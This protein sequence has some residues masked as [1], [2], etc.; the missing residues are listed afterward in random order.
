MKKQY[1]IDGMFFGS[2]AILVLTD[3]LWWFIQTFVLS[4]FGQ[5]RLMSIYM[6]IESLML[7]IFTG[8][9]GAWLDKHS[10]FYGIKV[11]LCIVTILS[12]ISCIAINFA[13]KLNYLNEEK[14][15]K[16]S[17]SCY[18]SLL[19]SVISTSIGSFFYN[20]IRLVLTKDWIVI[21]S[22]EF[23][24]NEFDDESIRSK[25]FKNDKKLTYYNTI[26][27][28]IYQIS[29]IIEPIITGFVMN[30]L[31]Y[32]MASI[33]FCIFNISMW[34]IISLF[35]NFIYKNV[36]R[37]KRIKKRRHEEEK[38]KTICNS[39]I[40]T[41]IN[42][43]KLDVKNELKIIKFL[44][45]PVSFVAVA[46]SLT[47]MNILQLSG[48]SIT[49]ASINNV[50]EQ[51]L[52]LFRCIGS[53]FALIGTILYPLFKKFFGLKKT[54]FIGFFM[55][56]IFLLPSVISI[57]LPGSIFEYNIFFKELTNINYSIYI[58]LIGITFSRLG[59]FI[60]DCAVNQQMQH[61]I[62]EEIRSEIFGIHTSL[63]Y[64]LTLLSAGL[65]FL[66]PD[67]KYFGF[68]IILSMIELIVGIIF[69]II[70]MYSYYK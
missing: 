14:I 6:G 54:G 27:A 53:I 45:H 9:G 35:L 5:F 40:S 18:F 20:L 16:I 37:L 68:F 28:L 30:Y 42:D 66:F 22:K 31:N 61:M 34:I 39:N 38:L 63:S 1:K 24:K 70:H 44:K 49:Y 33:V 41:C 17:N 52:N 15:N 25:K 47:Y 48:V 26:S 50:S 57:F 19:I 51:S 3:R 46:L 69:Y 60:G 7:M 56:Q 12:I 2:F 11:L 67:P 4:N 32:Q 59:L 58:Y 62:E 43:N 23:K 65:I 21:L 36:N 13:F 29:F 10:R 8:Y 64:T 55:Q